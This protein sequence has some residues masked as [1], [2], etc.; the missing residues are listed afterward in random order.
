MAVAALSSWLQLGPRNSR[1]FSSNWR[2][3]RDSN[4]RYTF[5]VHNG[6]ANRRLQP[7]GHPSGTN[8]IAERPC[9]GKPLS[10]WPV[11][12]Q[13]MRDPEMPTHQWRT[14]AP[15]SLTDKPI[16]RCNDC[17]GRVKPAAVPRHRRVALALRRSGPASIP[18]RQLRQVPTHQRDRGSPFALD[19]LRNKPAAPEI[20]PLGRV[21]IEPSRPDRRRAAG[22]I[23]RPKQMADIAAPTPSG[24]NEHA[25]QPRR[26][27]GSFVEIVSREGGCPNRPLIQQQDE[28]LRRSDLRGASAIPILN[29]V[30]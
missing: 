4:P 8:V 13:R 26:E 25:G 28:R 10:M 27:L 16:N 12:A 1:P 14:L 20:N 9:Q 23:E 21:G 19:D 29:L 3:G 17:V 5:T 15:Q 18:H 2:R 6:L 22:F 11:F 30:H 7:L 24:H